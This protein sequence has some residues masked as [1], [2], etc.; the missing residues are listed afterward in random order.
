MES[1]LQS[2]TRLSRAEVIARQGLIATGHPLASA[3][4]LRVL[5]DGGNAVDAAVAAAGVLGVVQP[6][7]SG[8][9][10][11]TFL[12]YW[13]AAARRLH[14]LNGSGIAPYAASYDWFASRGHVKMPGRGMLS[15]S[16]PGAVDAMATALERWGSGT[17]GLADLLQPAIGYA[18]DGFPVAPK[19]A[20][21]IADAAA[22]LAEYPSSAKVFLPRGR[23]PA[24][25][26]VL[27]M[28]DLAGSLRAV[29]AG[30]RD[31]F[32]RGDLARRIV[33]YMRAHGGLMTEREFAEHHSVIT[34]PV[35]TT[36]RGHVVY[37][38]PP[39]SQGIILLEVL[40]IL[41]GFPSEQLRWASAQ[42]IHLMVEAKKL[43][44]ADRLA[45]LGDPEFVE[46]PLDMLRSKEFAARRRDA[47]DPRRAAAG[48]QPGA[49]PEAVGDT[50]YFCVADRG[51]NVVSYITSL[52]ASFGCGELI[53]GTGIMLN[54][55]AG[56]GF[57]LDPAHPNGIAPGK[58]TMHTLMPFM[59][60][61]GDAPFLVWGTP[62]GDGQPQWN[63][64]V[65]SNLV[66]GGYGVQRA[67][68]L[69]R[70]M[71][72]PS[73]DPANLPAPFE[74]RLEPGFPGGTAAALEALGH[75]VREMGEMESGGASQAILVENGVYRGGSD[76]RVDGCAIGY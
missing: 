22:V 61:R 17:F 7:M 46:N 11:D 1:R 40:N 14:A 56:R 63:T 3:A 12:L 76:P 32:Y 64:Q 66:D 60:F 41:E 51:G 2:P 36:Y 57:V 55:R 20:F 49:I 8:L 25:G 39:P 42:T 59:A 28:K 33:G 37:T 65:F 23:P 52:S 16:V 4:G 67:I 10:A 73:T 9:G 26:D 75:R 44:V 72:F 29:A 53:D 71:S 27:V 13:D 31:E 38:T 24:P 62:G 69:P 21:W 74:V 30:G 5:M 34:A 15:V 47:I 18:E 50:T 45:Y 58:R 48:P 70:W 43:A 19:V 54:N 35:S 68:D 6:M